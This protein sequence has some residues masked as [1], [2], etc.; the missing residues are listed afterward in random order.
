[1]TRVWLIR[2]GAST[3]SPG[4]AIGASDPP[5]SELGRAQ[6]RSL[7]G[8]LAARPL[9]RVLSSDLRRAVETATAIAAPHRVVV[10]STR[11]LREIDFGQW[12]GRDL[13]DLWVEDPAAGRA[14]ERDVRQTPMSFGENT[15]D[16]ERRVADFWRRTS[17]LPLPATGEIAVVGHGGSLA[18]L[19]ALIAGEPLADTIASRLELGAMLWLDV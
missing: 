4:L 16:V 11:A 12:E 5:L 15:D 3:A 1:V 13:S 18:A 19:R 8:L 14:W 17:T 7:A 2:H 9:V 10:E 6:A